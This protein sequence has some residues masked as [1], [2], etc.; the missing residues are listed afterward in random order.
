MNLGCAF[1]QDYMRPC[2]KYR[3]ILGRTI[4]TLKTFLIILI[5]YFDSF[6]IYLK[7]I[8]TNVRILEVWILSYFVIQRLYFP[9]SPSSN[10]FGTRLLSLRTDREIDV[11]AAS[12]IQR[13]LICPHLWHGPI[14]LPC[15]LGKAKPGE[16]THVVPIPLVIG[17]I[18]W[19]PWWFMRNNLQLSSLGI[20]TSRA[21]TTQS[22][23]G[24][25][26]DV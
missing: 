4:L 15:E 25:A 17:I 13:C 22:L 3:L 11:K 18:S 7:N 2:S 8:S 26:Q 19:R 12:T 10:S 24:G 21:V 6:W 5:N 1:V 16:L 23:S 14:P 20:N 9:V